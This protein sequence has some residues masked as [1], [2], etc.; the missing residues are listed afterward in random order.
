[1][2]VNRRII[3]DWILENKCVRTGGYCNALSWGVTGYR[4]TDGECGGMR[5]AVIIT[6]A[7]I[8]GPSNEKLITEIGR[9]VVK[10]AGTPSPKAVMLAYL[11]RWWRASE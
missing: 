11:D 8:V 7:I 5:D 4:R 2:F 10:D 3:L 9:V 1:M 6:L